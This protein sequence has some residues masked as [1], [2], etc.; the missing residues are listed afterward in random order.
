MT[1]VRGIECCCVMRFIL[2]NRTEGS[3]CTCITQTVCIYHNSLECTDFHVKNIFI[4]LLLS[5]REL[6]AIQQLLIMKPNQTKPT[7]V[8]IF[9]EPG[10]LWIYCK[11]I[12]NPVFQRVISIRNTFFENLSSSSGF[13]TRQYRSSNRK[14]HWLDGFVSWLFDWLVGW[15]A[16]AV[17]GKI[18]WMKI[19][20]AMDLFSRKFV[21]FQNNGYTCNLQ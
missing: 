14:I 12:C 1:V 20:H 4:P 8:K 3:C 10:I 17:M 21:E 6:I 5:G 16:L 19:S 11:I 2:V 13:K 18:H 15:L 7:V 9:F